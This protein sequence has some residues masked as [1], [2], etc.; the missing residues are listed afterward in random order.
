MSDLFR[1]EDISTGDYLT[2]TQPT[3]I[4][5]F[6]QRHPSVTTAPLDEADRTFNWYLEPM[7][8][9]TK[10]LIKNQANNEYVFADDSNS[11]FLTARN[12]G[13]N[14]WSVM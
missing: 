1:I 13:D 10:F 9:C 3:E 12:V 7:D 5:R 14:E 6:S 2:Y 8:K 11:I 4:P